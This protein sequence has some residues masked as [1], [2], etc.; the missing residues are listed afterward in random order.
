[1]IKAVPRRIRLRPLSNLSLRQ[2]SRVLQSAL[3]TGLVDPAVDD[4][5]IFHDLDLLHLKLEEVKAAFP[6]ALN[7]AAVKANPVLGVLRAVVAQGFGLEAASTSELRLAQLSGA[8]PGKIVFDSPAKKADELQT[9]L[10]AGIGVNIDSVQEVVR[11]RQ[12]LSQKPKQTT[13]CFFGLRVNPETSTGSISSTDV[14]APQSK[15]GIP[16]SQRALILDL[17]AQ[18]HWIQGLHVHVGSQAYDVIAHAK[19]VAR[20]EALR[21]EADRARPPSARIQT[22][23]IGGG[24]SVTYQSDDH[25]PT[26][27]AFAQALRRFAPTLYSSESRLVTEFG[28]YLHAKAGWV[29]SRVEY[30]KSVADRKIAVI[31]VG[32]DMLLRECYEPERWFHECGICNPRGVLK[33]DCKVLC[34]VAG[35]LCFSG[36]VPARRVSLPAPQP[37]DYILFNDVGAYTYA[38]WSRYLSRPMPKILG[39]SRDK[40]NRPCF[41]VIKKR[42]TVE[43]AIAQWR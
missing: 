43:Q 2:I 22:M 4:S 16:L 25:A 36:D 27:A 37:G 9:A 8:S 38:M 30:T 1:M 35:P 29:C 14:S 41:S 21:Q 42:E 24:L 40:E 7:T 23:N 31:H 26:D 12:L 10:A 33:S 19:A 13:R 32:A 20:V 17:L 3:E 39:Y 28:R 6:H 15:F 34:D 5:V 11:V 18:N